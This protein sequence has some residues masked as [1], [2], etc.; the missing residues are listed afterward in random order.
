MRLFGECIKAL[1][2]NLL[3]LKLNFSDSD[4]G[5]NPDNINYL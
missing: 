4:L 5:E 2:K 1:P 3:N